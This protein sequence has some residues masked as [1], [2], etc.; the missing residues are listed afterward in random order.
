[1]PILDNAKY[2]LFANEIARG[3]AAGD[4]YALAGFPRDR[5]NASRLLARPEVKARVKELLEAVVERTLWTKEE[6]TED[7][8]RIASTAERK[9]RLGEIQ[10]LNI[11]RQALMDI[12]KL[13]GLLIDKS[14]ATVRIPSA[15][16]EPI[17]SDEW[18]E[19]Y[20]P[21]GLSS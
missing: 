10:G 20:A 18:A 21:A 9:A 15:R 2:E 11:A 6:L 16:R 1:M 4:A 5:G 12:A 19:R 3:T 7:L 8:A 17:S 14:E 13:N